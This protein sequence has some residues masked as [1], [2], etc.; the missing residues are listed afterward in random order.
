MDLTYSVLSGTFLDGSKHSKTHV[1]STGSGT[2]NDPVRVQSA[3]VTIQEFWIRTADGE[4][5]KIT[6]QNVDVDARHGHDIAMVIAENDDHGAYIGYVNFSTKQSWFFRRTSTARAFAQGAAPC[7][8]T[9]ASAFIAGGVAWYIE[10]FMACIVAFAVGLVAS[11]VVRNIHAVSIEAGLR[12][13]FDEI[14][15]EEAHR[16]VPRESKQVEQPVPSS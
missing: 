11:V 8:L 2:R 1:F 7:V 5:E 3:E 12:K 16:Y 6:L 14:I 10:G 9:I 15:M 4:E 13:K